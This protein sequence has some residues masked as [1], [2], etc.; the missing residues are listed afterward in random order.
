MNWVISQKVIFLWQVA[1][2][3]SPLF[4]IIQHNYID[5]DCEEDE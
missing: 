3:K 1:L 2:D 5:K 4:H